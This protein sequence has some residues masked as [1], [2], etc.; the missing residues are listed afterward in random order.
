MSLAGGSPSIFPSRYGVESHRSPFPPRSAAP[1]IWIVDLLLIWCASAITLVH[2]YER[3]PFLSGASVADVFSAFSEHDAVRS[4]PHQRVGFLSRV[5]LRVFGLRTR[6]SRNP[7]P[8]SFL[9]IF[10]HPPDSP[11][12]LI[13]GVS[14]NIGAPSRV[15]WCV[16]PPQV[17]VQR[18]S[19]RFA[20]FS[21]SPF[22]APCRMF[23]LLSYLDTNS[24]QTTSPPVCG[25]SSS[26]PARLQCDSR[27]TRNVC[28]HDCCPPQVSR[29]FTFLVTQGRV[30]VYFLPFK[31]PRTPS[32][33]RKAPPPRSPVFF[34]PIPVPPLAH[35]NHDSYVSPTF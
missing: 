13:K 16:Y 27:P 19:T 26:I 32:L 21:R 7:P 10:Q 33:H 34:F 5:P 8:I 18:R 29:D 17:M 6:S 31:S 4:V 23:C 12:L 11:L 22:P 3:D 30:S 2:L 35:R 1:S 14:R 15:V 25:G 9:C 20:T 24:V 28:V